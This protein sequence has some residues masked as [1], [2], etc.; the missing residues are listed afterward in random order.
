MKRYCG[1]CSLALAAALGIAAGP[2]AAEQLFGAIAFSPRTG[3]HGWS[4]GYA[5]RGE[6]E[7]NAQ[8]NCLKHASDCQL[9]TWFR[10]ACGALAVGRNGWG[11]DWGNTQQEAE[12]AAINACRQHTRNCRVIQRQCTR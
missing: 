10:D 2:A 4:I 12:T 7:E 6:A 3:A 11:A 8:T 1:L 9:A 5:T